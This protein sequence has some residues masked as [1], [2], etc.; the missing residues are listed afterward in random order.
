[1]E[2]KLIYMEPIQ[3]AGLSAD[4]E[5]PRDKAR[6]P[7]LWAKLQS[8]M[9][10]I[11]HI[12]GPAM[13]I[14]ARSSEARFIRYSACF[15]VSNTQDLPEG[16]EVVTVPEGNYVE[17]IHRGPVSTLFQ[18]CDGIYRFWLPRSGYSAGNGPMLEIYPENFKG[19]EENAEIRLLISINTLQQ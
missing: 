9:S 10:E 1:M 5:M 12:S 16:L 14:V 2:A 17:F 4:L 13:G 6:I 7:A 15:Q 18:T 11:N 3:C 8:R 19:N